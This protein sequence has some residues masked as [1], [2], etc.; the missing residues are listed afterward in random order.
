M[1]SSCNTNSDMAFAMSLL[2][3]QDPL[4]RVVLFATLRL[5]IIRCV[6]YNSMIRC[7]SYDKIATVVK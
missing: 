2:L 1:S 4:V 5:E 3:T 6:S 7:V